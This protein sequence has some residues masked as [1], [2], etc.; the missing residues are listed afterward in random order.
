M[1]FCL[2]VFGRKRRLPAMLSLAFLFCLG[3]MMLGCSGSG[4]SVYPGI[5]Q[6]KYTVT[7]TGTSGSG[8]SAITNAVQ[9]ALTVQ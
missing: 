8:A 4:V 5:P 2:F 7:V 6:G 9:V 1:A 3:S